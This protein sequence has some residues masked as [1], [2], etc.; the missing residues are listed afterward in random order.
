M[1]EVGMVLPE[2]LRICGVCRTAKHMSDFHG[3][4]VGS[5]KGA[6]YECLTCKRLRQNREYAIR[7][8][9]K[10]EGGL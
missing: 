5:R 9:K 6:R 4:E 8:G 2:G 3:Y 7:K 1:I 10:D